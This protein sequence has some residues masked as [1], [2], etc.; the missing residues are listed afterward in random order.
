MLCYAMLC[1]VK[2][3]AAVA[4]FITDHF[5][6]CVLVANKSDLLDARGQREF[7]AEVA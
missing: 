1:F 3:D 4:S 6:S 7:E 5:K 2:A